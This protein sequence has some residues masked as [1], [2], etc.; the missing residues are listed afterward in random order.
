MSLV[1]GILSVCVSVCVCLCV[2]LCVCVCVSAC[3][4]ACTCVQHQI[5]K[6]LPQD[7]SYIAHAQTV[8][9]TNV[10]YAWKTTKTHCKQVCTDSMFRE[11]NNIVHVCEQLCVHMYMSMYPYYLCESVCVC[12]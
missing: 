8:K 5:I 2:C 12:S 1:S 4:Y 3:T 9:F 7:Y 10:N 6:L 11:K